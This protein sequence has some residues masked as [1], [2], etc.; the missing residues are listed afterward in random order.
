MNA[1]SESPHHTDC[2]ARLIVENMPGFAWS[3]DQ[4]GKLRYL[5]QRFL[6]YTGNR[7]EDVNRVA[8]M[9]SFGRTGVLHPD[10]VAATVKAVAHAV[11]TGDPYVVEHRIRR[12]DGTYRWFRVSA[13][14]IRDP[15]SQ[16]IGW[17]GVDIDIDDQKR[18]DAALR[19]SERSLNRLIETL[20]AM[21]WRA[22]PDGEPDYINPRLA[23]YT[24]RGLDGVGRGPEDVGR[25]LD[26]LVTLKVQNAMIHQDDLEAAARAWARAH[27]T[28]AA[29]DL[30]AR[31]RGADGSYRWFQA[32][33][34]PMRD[35][36]GHIVHWYGVAVDIDDRKRAEE[37]LRKSEQELRGIVD[38]IP[39]TIV[40]L[41]PDGSG[42]YAN[43]PLLDYTGLTME[44]LMAPDSRGNP[45]LFHPEDWARLQDERRQGLSRAMP[46][47]IEWRVRRNDGQY[48]WFLVRY[49]PLRDEQG[50]ILRW[51]ASGTDI[52][53]R[54]RAEEAL[55]NS[56][57]ELRLLIETLPAMVWRTTA[58]GEP[59]YI[60]QRYADYLG[61]SLAELAQQQWREIVHPD[62]VATA[63]REW[64]SARET[65]TPL[66][67]TCRFRKADG[68]YRWFHVHAE[69]LRDGDGRVV[70]WYGVNVDIDDQK[71]TEEAL[72]TTQA[73]LSRAS[74]IATVSEL[75]ASIAHE[76]SQPLA[77]LVANSHAIQRWLS[78]EPPNLERAQLTAERII[79]DGNAA[80]EVVN[81]IRALFKRTDLSRTQLDLNEVIR[82][83]NR[84]MTDKV[85]TSDVRIETDLADDVPPIWA[86]RVQMQQVIANLARNGVEAMESEESY[87]KV[88]SIH[89]RRDG[90][91]SVLIEIRD[92][93]SGLEDVERVFEPFFTTKDTG[94]GMGLT[95]CR[96][97]VEAHQ[98][99]L[100]AA[101]NNPRGAV[102]SFTLPISSS[103]S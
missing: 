48:R 84:L 79:R 39:Q 14:R 99:R 30:T 32:R 40:V 67:T 20:P 36:G 37:G 71:R 13:L 35:E 87:P 22:T 41:G 50:R 10:D 51:Y 42:L 100:W 57:Q 89:S 77:A 49:H 56:E 8:G 55:R 11:A 19:E 91:N 75:A 65:E 12:F 7:I 45:V 96:W 98:G 60:N 6:E 70:R 29:L 1:P 5:N 76:V 17:Y 34:E 80:A 18:T 47:D 66:D 31:L 74:E 24:G 9:A 73:K 83:V 4:D 86:D 43:R 2:E 52:D 72:R 101:R 27:E 28:Q 69:P 85:A 81:R 103:A 94:M 53:D 62:D 68:A 63:A 21:V 15:R 93:G 26:D 90:T 61:R 23:N 16:E 78:A 92:H 54:K 38:A 59:D 3:A 46:F 82:E 25:T 33:A 88:L 58:D 102:F 64:T 95:I 97:I 44:Q